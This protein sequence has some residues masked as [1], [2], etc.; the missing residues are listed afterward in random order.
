MGLVIPI[1]AAGSCA[2][3]LA[4]WAHV[5]GIVYMGRTMAG[6]TWVHNDT[7]VLGERVRVLDVA[8]TYQSATY[9][10]E[11]W[12]DPVFPYHQLFDHG[13]DAWPT[14]EDLMAVAV[15]G[16]GGYAIPKH[17]I[18]HH[19]EVA[20]VDVVEIDPAIQH[21][22]RKHF[23][24]DRLEMRYGAER[25]GRL[26]LHADDAF[27]WLKHNQQRYDLIINDCFLGVHPESSLMTSN[28]AELFHQHLTKHGRYLTN[29]VSALEGPQAR[30]LY[31]TIEALSSVFE[32][33]WVYP[34]GMDE[35]SERENNVVIASDTWHAFEGAWEWPTAARRHE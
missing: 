5:R 17:L 1:S 31:L 30:P 19:P 6:W 26:T 3:L 35:P 15:L 4:L 22:A 2:C 29:V 18:A 16:G 8:G 33:V 23:F 13:F 9:L 14:R 34:C 27:A 10:D 7:R 25:S 32:H 12:A 24:L 11:R 20:H 21:I 28:A